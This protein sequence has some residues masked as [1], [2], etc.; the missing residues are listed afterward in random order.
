MVNISKNINKQIFSVIF[1]IE[2]IFVLNSKLFTFNIFM[3]RKRKKKEHCYSTQ[4]IIRLHFNDWNILFYFKK[5]KM[6]HRSFY[7]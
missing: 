3:D 6:Q 2:K 5:L 7:S 4:T 1:K